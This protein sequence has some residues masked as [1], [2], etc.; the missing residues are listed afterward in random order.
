MLIFRSEG[1]HFRDDLRLA[2]CFELCNVC[3][4]RGALQSGYSVLLCK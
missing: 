2:L 1:L 4:H 3:S